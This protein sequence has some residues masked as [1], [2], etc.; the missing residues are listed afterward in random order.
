[1]NERDLQGSL[2][3]YLES[4]AAQIDMRIGIVEDDDVIRRLI[5]DFLSTREDLDEVVDAGS[6][7]EFF[8]LQEQ[9]PDFDVILSDIGLPGM[10]G[11]DG[12]RELKNRMPDCEI[13]M[14]TV[15]KDNDNIFK[16][17]CAGASGYLLK[18]S[19]LS[20]I[21]E[22]VKGVVDGDVPMTPSIARE[23]L[24]YFN[25][26]EKSSKGSLSSSELSVVECLVDGMSYKMIMIADRLG[27]SLNTVKFHLKNIYRKLHVNSK[28]EVIAKHLRGEI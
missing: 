27:I 17:L 22:A 7:E 21:Y 4:P 10:S 12:I 14:L 13:L 6:M 11:I 9:G 8:V 1:M 20:E 15:Y 5:S 16:S 28:A 3:S 25:R 2:S 19:P 26:R 24:R 18:S 23:V